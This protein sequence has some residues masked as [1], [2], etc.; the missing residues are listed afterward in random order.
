MYGP[1]IGGAIGTIGTICDTD[2]L[3]SG[4][5]HFPANVVFKREDIVTDTHAGKDYDFITW[6]VYRLVG[7]YRLVCTML[8]HTL[9]L[10]Q[11]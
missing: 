3:R 9:P 7:W 10:A 4:S 2:A 5:S 8:S 1:V 6:C 11:L